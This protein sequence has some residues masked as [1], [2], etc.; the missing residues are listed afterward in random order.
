MNMFRTPLQQRQPSTRSTLTAAA[1]AAALLL[2]CGS[3]LRADVPIND[4]ENGSVGGFGWLTGDSRGIIPWNPTDPTTPANGTIITA[5]SGP[6]TGSKVLEMTGTTAFNLGQ[7]GAAALGLDFN[8]T[9]FFANDQLEFDWYPLPNGGDAGYSQ[10]Y[11]IVVN[12]EG[13]GWN[14]AGGFGN[15]DANANQYYFTGYTG[16]LHHVVVD[17]TGVKNNIQSGTLTDG[18]GW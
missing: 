15:G 8:R 10:L 9:A 18:G 11:N 12:S 13:G 2:A 16:N 5:T 7:A 14:A 4:F 17:Y 1:G 6:L 3:V